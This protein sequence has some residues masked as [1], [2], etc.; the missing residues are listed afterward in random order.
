VPLVEGDQTTNGLLITHLE[1]RLHPRLHLI[2]EH[3]LRQHSI[4]ICGLLYCDSSC[5]CNLGIL[6]VSVKYVFVSVKLVYVY[7][8][9]LKI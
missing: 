6:F 5:A 9:L 7:V 3:L 4:G 1:D 2:V 8:K